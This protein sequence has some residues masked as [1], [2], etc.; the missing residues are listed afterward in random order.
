MKEVMALIGDIALSKKIEDRE[1]F[2]NKISLLFK[3]ISAASKDFLYSP[4]TLTLGDEFQAV[5]RKPDSIMTDIWKI[6]EALYP[7]RA[8]FAIGIDI[9]STKI[10]P[11]KAIGM[12]GPAFYLARD[13]I[14][15]LKQYSR[16]VIQFYGKNIRNLNLIDQYLILLSG[17]S[18][19][20][21]LNTVKI[22][23]GLLNKD[24]LEKI[25]NNTG[26]SKR[27]I[28]KN[29]RSNYLEEIIDLQR[30]ITKSLSESIE[31]L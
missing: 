7:H 27:A 29:I 19:R 20:W 28:Y 21:K 9:L 5:Y 15:E 24:S 4:Y 1:N 2:Q 17:I 8:R 6:I 31:A 3:K 25:S 18:S 16:T 30:E 10:N 12:D 13:G 22:L 11:N 14:E 26:I 23:N